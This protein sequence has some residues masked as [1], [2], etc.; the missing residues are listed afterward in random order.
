M[1]FEKRLKKQMIFEKSQIRQIRALE[2]TKCFSFK[3]YYADGLKRLL[4]KGEA[5]LSLGK[6]E[7]RKVWRALNSSKY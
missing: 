1:K 3:D 6:P 7:R 5:H 4:E 2:E